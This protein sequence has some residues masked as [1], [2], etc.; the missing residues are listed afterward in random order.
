MASTAKKSTAMPQV[1]IALLGA[2][3]VWGASYLA[4]KELTLNHS[5]WGMMAIRFTFAAAILAIIGVFM[6]ARLSRQ[7]IWIGGLIGAGLAVVMAFETN[8]IA[9]TSATNSGLIISLSIIFTPIIEGWVRKSWLPRNFFIAAFGAIIGV[10][11]LIGG[12]G[13]SSP[14]WGDALMLIAAVLRAGYQVFQA[15][16]TEGKT[17][18]TINLTVFQTL[19]AGLIFFI[20]DAPGTINAVATYGACEWALV[21]FLIL[22]CTVYGFFAMMW[23]IRKTSASRIALLQGT[24]PVWAV[25][26]AV[27][28]GGEF[29]G[30]IGAIG[31]VLIIGSCYFGLGIETKWRERQLASVR[32]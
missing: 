22:F 1:D 21:G 12:N 10:A 5:L 25:G 16:L 17:L 26:V 32:N 30:W 31:A 13:I 3:A 7:E 2:A 9:I 8:G 29:M 15:K 19:I 28:I 6:R 24:E 11:F 4:S 14:N 20:V 23:G 27:V 18:N